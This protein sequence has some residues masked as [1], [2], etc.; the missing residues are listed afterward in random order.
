MAGGIRIRL[1]ITENTWRDRLEH[2]A[3]PERTLP[4]HLKPVLRDAFEDTQAMV[5]IITGS[6]KASGRTDDSYDEAQH[7]WQGSITYGGPS[8]GSIN[9]PVKYAWYEAR[10]GGAH[11]FMLNVHNHIDAFG[12]GIA[13][14]MSE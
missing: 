2:L 10:R 9:D 5:H 3:H 6:L 1:R 13:D 12:Q 11:D 8:M 7:T 4:D 14:W